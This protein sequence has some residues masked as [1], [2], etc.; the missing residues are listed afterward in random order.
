MGERIDVRNLSRDS[1]MFGGGP[2]ALGLGDDP[3][4]ICV[5]NTALT[6]VRVAV[7]NNSL[8]PNRSTRLARCAVKWIE[9]A[10]GESWSWERG[11]G[12]REAVLLKHPFGRVLGAYLASGFTMT[13]LPSPDDGL[14]DDR[15]SAK[16]LHSVDADTVEFYNKSAGPIAVQITTLSSPD[17]EDD[18]WVNVPSGSAKTWS[19]A[20]PE[21]A[22]LRS[23]DGTVSAGIVVAKAGSKIVFYGLDD[24]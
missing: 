19:R 12:A 7:T 22:I 20:G 15:I 8:Y 23:I 17:A 14:M 18:E 5:L 3:E 10:P 16:V 1:P 21:M 4:A 13:V 11:I 6:L 9:L 2:F 24:E